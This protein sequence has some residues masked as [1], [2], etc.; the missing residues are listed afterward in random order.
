MVGISARRAR[1]SP[2]A[3]LR[4]EITRTILVGSCPALVLS[5]TACRF[6]PLPEIRTVTRT[7][8]EDILKVLGN[9]DRR[10]IESLGRVVS[11]LDA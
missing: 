3:S 10:K 5:I 2:N 1:S 7:G 6:D 8:E 9:G 11:Q 4:F